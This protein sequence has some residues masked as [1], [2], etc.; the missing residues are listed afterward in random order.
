MSAQFEG[1]QSIEIGSILVLIDLL[2]NYVFPTEALVS[3][4]EFIGKTSKCRRKL[5][6]TF[7]FKLYSEFIDRKLKKSVHVVV[8][9]VKDTVKDTMSGL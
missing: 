5:S 3:L 1:V 2:L 9:D 8:K 4:I 6:S 7:S